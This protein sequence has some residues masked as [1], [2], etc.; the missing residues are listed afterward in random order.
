MRFTK[1]FFALLLAA[2]LFIL[3]APA[4]ADCAVPKAPAAMPDGSA[5]SAEEMSAAKS[6]LDAFEKSVH[7]FQACVEGESKTK[8]A[9]LGANVDAIRQVKL[10]SEKRVTTFNDELQKHADAYTEQMRA[11]KLANRQ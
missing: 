9:A 10:M 7:Q 3:A 6:A 11:W 1:N 2:P 8:I 4:I 5:A